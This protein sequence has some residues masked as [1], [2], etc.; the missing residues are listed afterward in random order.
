MEPIEYPGIV[1]QDIQLAKV[2]ERCSHG[3]PPVRFDGHVQLDENGFASGLDDLS[4]DCLTLL[5]Q[6]VSQDDLGALGGEES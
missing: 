3:L 5:F 4:L 6:D 1:D 2:L